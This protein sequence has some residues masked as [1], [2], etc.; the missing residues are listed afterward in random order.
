MRPVVLTILD[1]WGYS[2]Q[3]LGNAI[4][5]AKTP[6]I[7]SIQQN[8]PSLLLQ[9]SGKAAGMTW[10]ESG[11]SE[12]GHLTIGAGRVI[13]QY[14]SRINKAIDND[15]FFS[16]EVLTKAIGH[17]HENNSTL[18]LAGLLTSGSVHSYLAHLFALVDLAKKSNIINLKIHLFTDGKDSGLKEAP[19]LIKKVEDYLSQIGI[20]KIST[21]IG[22]DFAMDRSQD[23]DLTKMAYELLTAGAGEKAPDIY[24][25]LDEY[26]LNGFNDSKIPPTVIDNTGVIRENDAL[27]F[28]NFREDSMRQIVEAFV[29]KEFNIFGKKELNNLYVASLTQYIENASLHVAFPIPEIKDGLAEV[30]S[31]NSKK[32]YHIAETEKYAHVTYFFNC[33]KNMPFDGETDFL[34]KS[35]KNPLENPEMKTGDIAEKVLSE[36]DRYDFFVINFANGDILSHFGNLEAAVRGIKAIDNVLGKIKSAVLERGGTMI[37]TAD[38]GNAESLTYKSSGESET[39]HNDNPVLFYLI[40]EEFERHRSDDD[41]ASTMKQSSGL[42][43]DIAPTILEL[44]GIEKPAEMTGESLLKLLK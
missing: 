27:I 41:I 29:G 10:G 39:K 11:N 16:N 15:S 17:V 24:K 4:L 20:G 28:F 7:D 32:Q 30:L 5:N 19:I 23:W 38:H 9:A 21:I 6:N 40:G 13:F 34:S 43:A 12:V 33:L 1:G 26:Y 31:K 3:K 37:V 2:K 22:R 44:M 25:K 18:H 8:Y 14:L 35:L 36:L 42:L